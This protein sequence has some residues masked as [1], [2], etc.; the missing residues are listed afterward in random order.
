M[1]TPRHIGWLIAAAALLLVL[2]L[3]I[4]RLGSWREVLP[5]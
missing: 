5:W 1:N 4:R 2:D 3:A